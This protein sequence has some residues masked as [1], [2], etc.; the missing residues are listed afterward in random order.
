[1]KWV[2][3]T[4]G[5]DQLVAEMWRDLLVQEGVRALIRPGDTAS[6]M[7]VSGYPCRVMVW[8]DQLERAREVLE[9]HLGHQ[10]E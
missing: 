3:L 10:V 8:E 7:G 5:P 9:E 4:T 6:F 2:Y 1:M